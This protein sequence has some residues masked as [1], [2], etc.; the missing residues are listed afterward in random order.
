MNTFS[1]LKNGKNMQDANYKMMKTNKQLIGID[2]FAGAGGLSLGAEMAGISMRYA[3]E[4]DAYAAASYKR[5]FKNATVFC[6]DIRKLSADKLNTQPVFII[7]GG[8]PCQGFSLSN[9]KTRDMSNPNNR[10]F[11]E[12]LRFVDKIAPTWFVFENVY[13]LTK[14]KN[15]EENIQNHI[16]NRF[17]DIGYTVKSKI[18]YASDFGVP[19]RRNRLFIVG[20]RN[21]IDFEFPKE[22]DYSV[23]V[24]EAI[25]DLPVLGNA[26]IQMK[27]E[28]TVPFEQASPY[29]QLMRKKSK[30]PTQNIVSRN[31]DYVVERYKYIGQGENWSSIPDRLME[32]YA[33]KKRCHSGIYKRLIGGK[34]S[35]VISNYRKSML[36]HPHQDRGLSVREAARLQSFPDHFIFEG[37]VS[38]VQQQIGNAVPPLLAKAVMKKIL[39]YK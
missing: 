4:A 15:G 25:S 16:E 29:A 7:M 35:V 23:S 31:K 24:D 5:N 13:G 20:N 21:G 36:I 12:F 38:Y 22:F 6:E 33:D 2:L 14:F 18:L 39:T 1:V 30:A 27:G 34:P 17:R 11:E 8:P 9:T 37:P 10:M 32:N 28:Y 19:Q 26:E 3:V